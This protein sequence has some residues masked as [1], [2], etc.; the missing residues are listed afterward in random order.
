MVTCLK[1]TVQSN[2]PGCHDV[3]RQSEMMV[4]NRDNKTK[5]LDLYATDEQEKAW[6]LKE[7]DPF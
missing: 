3:I 4:H 1:H 2:V 6:S 5:H 7:V